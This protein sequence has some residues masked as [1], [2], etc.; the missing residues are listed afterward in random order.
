MRD[1]S[2][3]VAV[4]AALAVVL[5]VVEFS[6][7]LYA[8][9]TDVVRKAG[10]A[11]AE[12]TGSARSFD[13]PMS[14]GQVVAMTDRAYVT[15]QAVTQDPEG[16]PIPDAGR[17]L[18]VLDLTL[19]NRSGSDLDFQPQSQFQL[20]DQA[21]NRYPALAVHGFGPLTAGARA[22]A[23]GTPTRGQVAF[24][25]PRGAQGIGLVWAPITP[26]ILVV[27]GLGSSGD[28]LLSR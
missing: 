23:H 6:S 18:V 24:A 17:Q 16:W 5:G 21:N 13:R 20:T 22:L 1:V 2:T 7:S 11:Y 27:Q 26:T 28:V 8:E 10:G 4:V 19:V 14:V 3:V 9:V 15:L 25:V 12:M